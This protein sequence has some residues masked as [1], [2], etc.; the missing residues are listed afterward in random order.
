[1]IS[2][3]QIIEKIE[4]DLNFLK[5][6]FTVRWEKI[7]FDAI[8]IWYFCPWLSRRVTRYY[9]MNISVFDRSDPKFSHHDHSRL[10]KQLILYSYKQILTTCRALENVLSV[11]IETVCRKM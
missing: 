8:A 2:I 11:V 5:K 9:S 6:N 7:N 4:F 3:G 1:M 10:A